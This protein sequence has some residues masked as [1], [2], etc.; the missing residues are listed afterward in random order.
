M[1]SEG[2]CDIIMNHV[3]KDINIINNTVITD[4]NNQIYKIQ[5]IYERIVKLDKYSKNK[6]SKKI[7]TQIIPLIE[8]LNTYIVTNV[9]SFTKVEDCNEAI[10]IFTTFNEL[11]FK[12]VKTDKIENMLELI[13]THRYQLLNDRLKNNFDKQAFVELYQSGHLQF[14]N[15]ES[16]INKFMIDKK[17]GII[18][19]PNIKQVKDLIISINDIIQ[20]DSDKFIIPIIKGLIK[21][22]FTS[23]DYIFILDNINTFENSTIKQTYYWYVFNKFFSSINKLN[24]D[25][26][27]CYDSYEI[28]YNQLHSLNNIFIHISKNK[29]ISDNNDS[30]KSYSKKDIKIIKKRVVN[31]IPKK[32]IQND[33]MSDEEQYNDDDTPENIYEKAHKNVAKRTQRILKM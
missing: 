25:T 7:F 13:K 24:D 17:N 19:D 27:T 18:N 5:N 1:I 9:N 14:S 16:F 26:I 4:Y 23:N 8:K 2:Y 3:Q 29:I 10:K 32:E 11:V 33:I 20:N 6:K 15:Y 22:V 12:N 28:I 31:N 30:D 21:N